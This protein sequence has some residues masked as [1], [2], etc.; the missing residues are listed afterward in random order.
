MAQ[1]K[2]ISNFRQVKGDMFVY[3]MG[4]GE[5]GCRSTVARRTTLATK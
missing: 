5:V 2:Q 3:E 1:R 4:L